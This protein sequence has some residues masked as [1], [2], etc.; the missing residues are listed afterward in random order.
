MNIDVYIIYIH[1]YIFVCMLCIS[2]NLG[3]LPKLL[4]PFVFVIRIL[5]CWGL[6]WGPA[7]DENC[8]EVR[9]IQ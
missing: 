7:K 4:M 1:I 6:Y 8:R 5:V 2:G 9:G 3:V